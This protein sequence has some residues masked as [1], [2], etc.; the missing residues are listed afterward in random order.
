[1][2]N[3]T[4][5][6][7]EKVKNHLLTKSCYVTGT[8]C[9]KALFLQK[10]SPELIKIESLH[11]RKVKR[12]G[13][14][15]GAF[16]RLQFPGGV[17]IDTLNTDQALHETRQAIVSGA[18]TLFEAAF[19]A[20]GVL[21][22]ADILTR[23]SIDSAWRLYEV[24]ATTYRTVD[25]SSKGE[26]SRDLAI[27]TWVLQECGIELAGIFLMHLNHECSF[28]E[29]DNLFK[30]IDYTQEIGPILENINAD[31][32]SLQRVL[33]S[34]QYP[35]VN[36]GQQ[37]EKP[38]E[39]QFN[40]VC[41]KNIPKYS[42]FNIPRALNKWKLLEEN[43]FSANQ[44]VDADFKS[45][46][47]R[48]ALKCYQ[49][50]QPFYDL[51][52]A[53]ALLKTWTYPISY[54]DLEAIS[55][56]IPRYNNSRPYQDLPF[57]FSCHIQRLPE[58]ELEHHEFLFDADTDPREAFINEMLKVLPS[59][60]SIVVYHQTYEITKLNELAKDFPQYTASINALLPRIVDLKKVIEE[61]VYHPEFLGSYSIKKVAPVLLGQGVSY[62]HLA[63]GDGMEA[64]CKFQELV[65]L[66]L[67]DSRRDAVRKDLLEYCKQD[68]LLMAELKHWLIF[69]NNSLKENS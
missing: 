15:V 2:E 57:Q 66:D 19:M 67:N 59:V 16:A 54:F 69:K 9:S 33:Q 63:V 38:R 22:R 37:C 29:M 62:D 60:G 36:I 23:T 35:N 10:K 30:V 44:L 52:A 46:K 32:Q 65:K 68:T 48:R 50:N 43:R 31:I 25:A 58:A 47:Q 3:F 39:C 55:Y 8:R 61:S 40:A 27:Q 64:V 1:M 5:N 21:I 41:W 45:D 53:H 20:Q 42:V 24:K 17:L 49:T 14:E 28:P 11:D 7:N 51:Q 6:K 26:Y 18:L 56:P 12:E 13:A 34:E 4:S